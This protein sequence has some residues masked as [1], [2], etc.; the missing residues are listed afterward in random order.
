MRSGS[1]LG[2]FVG[3]AALV[4]LVPNIGHAQAL[5]GFCAPNPAIPGSCV[6][7]NIVTPIPTNP[8]SNF[9]FTGG[10]STQTGE[11]FI[12]ILI[13]NVGIAPASLTVTETGHPNVTAGKIDTA[14]ISGDL[15]AFL[16]FANVQPNNPLSAFP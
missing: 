2:A 12:D 14:W 13:P 16:G 5:H 11:L 10:G 4:A 8:P 6:D 15:S 3:A 7:N 9:T 1:V